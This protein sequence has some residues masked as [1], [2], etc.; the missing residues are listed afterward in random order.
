MLTRITVEV[1][2]MVVAVHLLGPSVS[3]TSN[4]DSSFPGNTPN[5]ASGAYNM[6]NSSPPKFRIHNL[7]LYLKKSNTLL[8]VL[9]IRCE[10]VLV[11]DIL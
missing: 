8:S 4:K 3:T 5:T 2:K 6:C 9:Y 7:T 11:V 10:M 1:L